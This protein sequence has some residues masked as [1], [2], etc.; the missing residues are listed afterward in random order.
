MEL[1]KISGEGNIAVDSKELEAMENGQYKVFPVLRDGNWVGLQHNMFFHPIIGTAE[2]PKVVQALAY[3]APEN[4]I[5]VP[6]S[7]N[8]NEVRDL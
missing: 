5:Y 4:L 2:N 8:Q 1:K 6:N 7:E 3:D